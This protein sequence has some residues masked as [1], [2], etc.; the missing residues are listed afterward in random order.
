[1]CGPQADAPSLPLLGEFS[2]CGDLGS[3]YSRCP[4]NPPSGW[5]HALSRAGLSEFPSQL[6]GVECEGLKDPRIS[7]D[8]VFRSHQ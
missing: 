7:D 8:S 4:T 6:G 5:S 2:Q 3:F 1:M